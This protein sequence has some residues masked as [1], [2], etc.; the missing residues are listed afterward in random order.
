MPTAPKPR[1]SR[2]RLLRDLSQ[3][4]FSLL[5][6]PPT[7]S[8][9]WPKLAHLEG[10]SSAV[11]ARSLLALAS[12]SVDVLL[13]LLDASRAFSDE[14]TASA[15]CRALPRAA[16][17]CASA[18]SAWEEP[19]PYFATCSDRRFSAASWFLAATAAR[20]RALAMSR[21]ASS[22]A[23]LALASAS[24]RVSTWALSTSVLEAAAMDCDQTFPEA[25]P[26]SL[27]A[28]VVPVIRSFAKFC[29]LGRTSIHTE[30]TPAMLSLLG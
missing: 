15:V 25:A 10:C 30:F 20:S 29:R 18:L 6:L 3:I 7:P 11:R 1:P 27:A 21:V 17:S 2:L 4:V 9:D 19:S 13:A 16:V 23:R 22:T 5:D 8:K 24:L 28:S 14:V 26:A 12:C